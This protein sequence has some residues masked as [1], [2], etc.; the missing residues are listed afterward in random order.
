MKGQLGLGDKDAWGPT[1]PIIGDSLPTVQL[2]TGRTA[3]ALATGSAIPTE[4]PAGMI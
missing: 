1:E 2:G 3:V 4:A